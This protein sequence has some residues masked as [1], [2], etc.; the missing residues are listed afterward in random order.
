MPRKDRGLRVDYI[1][2]ARVESLG[3]AVLYRSPV[4]FLLER[5]RPGEYNLEKYLPS[6]LPLSHVLENLS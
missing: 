6:A 5:D 2:G 4:A 3:L 1:Y